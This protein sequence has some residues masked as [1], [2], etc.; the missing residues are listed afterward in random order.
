M[1]ALEKGE[2]VDGQPAC[3]PGL[4]EAETDA[5]SP[6]EEE[7]DVPGRPLQV[8]QGEDLEQ[9]Q[10]D[11]GQ[12]DEGALVHRRQRRD[13]GAK[14][15]DGDGPEY[16]HQGQDLVPL[17]RSEAGVQAGYP[18]PEPRNGLL[19]GRIDQHE[20]PPEDK[21]HEDSHREHVI[22]QL[23]EP[24]GPT[25]RL[26]EKPDGH[27]PPG[28]PQERDDAPGPGHE[29]HPHEEPLPEPGGLGVVGIEG[30]YGNQKGID[31]GGH[32]GVRHDESQGRSHDETAQ[33]DHAGPLPHQPQHLVGQAPGQPRLG[34]DHSDHE[35]A[36]DEP[37]GGVHEI[38]ERVP[39]R[40]NQEEG[41]NH[42]DGDGR[43]AD[44]HHLRHPPG[45]RQEE[46]A[47]GQLTLPAQ[48]KAFT[49]RRDGFRRRGHEIEDR[50]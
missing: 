31:G 29:G 10:E 27:G 50:E 3:G 49:Q 43:D 44:G 19:L 5:H 6:T 34:E 37:D 40:T 8:V 33:V 22:A 28:R 21:G 20:V 41:L 36:D 2:P 16:E 26:G 9:E 47:H 45:G 17:H 12:K 7:D 24:D 11:G 1:G 23:E 15:Q 25:H 48:C 38:G 18:L 4:P 46:E 13:E 35:G 14:G 32:R 39:G 30:V 42:P